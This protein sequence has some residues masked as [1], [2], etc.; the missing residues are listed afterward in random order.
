MAAA[1]PALFLLAV[2][3]AALVA[4]H[5]VLGGVGVTEGRPAVGRTGTGPLFDLAR[6]APGREG[7]SSLTVTNVGT[8]SGTFVLGA[9]TSGSPALARRLVLVVT[10]RDR[11]LYHGSLAGLDAV[12]LALLAPGQRRTFELRAELGRGGNA[13]QGTTLGVDFLV[14]VAGV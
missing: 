13:L 9:F 14:T 3:V 7:T 6:L 4:V 5:P 12:R 10:D 2:V 11:E 1:R 8:G